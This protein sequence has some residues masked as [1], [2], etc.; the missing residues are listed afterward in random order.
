MKKKITI[1]EVN[2]YRSPLIKKDLIYVES[3][4]SAGSQVTLNINSSIQVEDWI[5]EEPITSPYELP[6]YNTDY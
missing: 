2:N 3:S 5:V 1:K 4:I 6:A